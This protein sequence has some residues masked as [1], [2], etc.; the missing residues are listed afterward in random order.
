MRGSR[1]RVCERALLETG[2][3]HGYHRDQSAAQGRG[4][5]R[6][7]S[8]FAARGTPCSRPAAQIRKEPHQPG[9]T[10]RTLARVANDP[11]CYPRKT[12]HQDH[13]NTSGYLSARRSG[14]PRGDRQGRAPLVCFVLHRSW[15]QC[16]GYRGGRPRPKH[17]RA[18]FHD[19]KHVWGAGQ[20]QVRNI[21]TNVAMYHLNLWNVYAGETEGLVPRPWG[22]VRS[23]ILPMGRSPAPPFSRGSSQSLAPTLLQTEISAIT[24]VW[25]LPRKIL[26]LAQWLM[27]LAT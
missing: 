18:K 13:Q 22:T 12:D 2:G 17:D 10:R 7:A 19:L 26:R 5:V 9:Q 21:W 4:A 11:L 25:P 15:S 23:Q 27:M 14:H 3:G 1:W 20:Q 8:C 6:S 16:G 24:A